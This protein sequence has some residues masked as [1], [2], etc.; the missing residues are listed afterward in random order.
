MTDIILWI[1]DLLLS[2]F[3]SDFA[4]AMVIYIAVI[5][6]ILFV[7]WECS[8]RSLMAYIR[9]P[10]WR[11]ACLTMLMGH[12]IF[13]WMWK[14]TEQEAVSWEKLLYLLTVNVVLDVFL[15]AWLFK[16]KSA[17][18]KKME[19]LFNERGDLLKCHEEW[20]KIDEKKLAPKDAKYWNRGYYYLM[21]QMGNI[22]K[23]ARIARKT[24]KE[25][26]AKYLE[27]QAL[28]EEA[29]GNI[30]GSIEF[31]KQALAAVEE[32]DR[33]LKA[34]LLNTETKLSRNTNCLLMGLSTTE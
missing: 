12:I 23:S 22:E 14:G 5:A 11:N 13:L 24:E 31:T 2:V 28:Y 6:G 29:R 15:F 33:Y 8:K 3:E 10:A 18:R 27:W 34:E 30:D 7:C 32:K 1:A 4:K 21:Y 26:S 20:L 16:G 17:V 25:G 19:G 9:V